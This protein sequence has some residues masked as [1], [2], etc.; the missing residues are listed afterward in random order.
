VEVLVELLGLARVRTGREAVSLILPAAATLGDV[1]RALAEVHPELVGPVLTREGG[2]VTGNLFSPDGRALTADPR[3]RL[4]AEETPGVRLL[5]LTSP[6][7][8]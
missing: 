2:L 4:S 3:T 1:G 8:G 6:E 5:L 7:G